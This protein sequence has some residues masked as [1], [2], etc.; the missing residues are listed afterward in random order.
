MLRIPE[1]EIMFN[2]DQALS[3]LENSRDKPKNLFKFFYKQL[4]KDLDTG[5]IVDLGCGPGD[6][7]IEIANLHNGVT[8]DGIDASQA[9]INI[10]NKDQPGVEFHCLP[11]TSITD[12]YDR[13]VSSM[14][15]HH[16]HNPVEFWNTIKA[17]KPKDVFVF[18]LI[19]PEDE[20]TLK[21]IIDNNGPYLNSIFQT[22]LENSLRAG[23]SIT[24]IK[25]QLVEC[26]LPL[27]VTVISKDKTDPGIAIVSGELIYGK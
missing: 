26:N 18:D 11:I 22:D 5:S 3:Y 27:T 16:F 13:V 25:E 4:L 21:G 24:E 12:N 1:P 2:K 19:R 15:L 6:L 10:T 23:F 20:E 8:I 9:M 7:T 17:I 14:T